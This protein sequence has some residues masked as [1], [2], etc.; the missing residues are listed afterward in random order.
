[1]KQILLVLFLAMI[2]MSCNADQPADVDTQAES[3]AAKA[4]IKELAGALQKELKGAMQAGGPVAAI[5]VCNTQ[6]MPITQKVATENG[7]RLSRVS[8]NNRNPANLPNEWQAAVLKD[9]E[10]QKAAGKDP[11]SLAWSETVSLDDGVDGGK[12]FRFMKAIP[13]AAVCLNC[14]GAEISP[15]VSQVLAGLYPDDR[16]TGYSEG[17][18]R[19]AFV[20]IRQLSD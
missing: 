17:D 20:A 8:L 2:A 14:H 4:A 19:G 12:E 1:M 11:A 5:G 6:A 10:Q 7:L 9:F 3:A 18:I 15:D 13:T 16:A